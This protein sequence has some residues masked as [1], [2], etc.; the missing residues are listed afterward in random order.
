[1]L[2]FLYVPIVL[3]GL[4][5]GVSQGQVI[6]PHAEF[7]RD[8]LKIGEEVIYS[9]SIRYPRAIDVVFPDSLYGFAPFELNRKISFSTKS[10]SLFSFDS[11]AYHL[12]TFEL[13]TFQILNLPVFMVT[14]GDSVLAYPGN[15]TVV[16]H[17]VVTSIPD[18][19][20]LK[21]STPYSTVNLGFNYPY[22]VVGIVILV[23]STLIVVFVFGKGIRKKFILHRLKR[24]HKKFLE[25]FIMEVSNLSSDDDTQKIEMLLATWKRYLEKLDSYPYTKLTSPEIVEHNEDLELH[26]SLQHIDGAIY[27]GFRDKRLNASFDYLRRISED[28]FHR[29]VMEIQ[30]G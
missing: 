19:I 18:S 6:S 23:I 10:D 1:M 11:A 3:L 17:Q 13:D 26:R 14:S 5:S 27:G 16:L 22:V 9:L 28:I 2:K 7:N 4:F 25:L 20:A 24:L 29:R 15:D 30:N 8:S 21:A 12:T